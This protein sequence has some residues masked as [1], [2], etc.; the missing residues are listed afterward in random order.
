MA[1]TA[2]MFHLIVDVPLVNYPQ[3]KA[4]LCLLGVTV[5]MAKLAIGISNVY[6]K[7]IPNVKCMVTTMD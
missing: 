5:Q 6:T 7:S 3:H 2:V 1:K 4:S